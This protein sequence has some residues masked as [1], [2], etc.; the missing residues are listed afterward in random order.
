MADAIQNDAAARGFR[1]RPRG[2]TTADGSSYTNSTTET[3]LDSFT[4]AANTIKHVGDELVLEGSINITSGNS[5]DTLAAKL[6]LGSLTLST[7]GAADVA[8]SGD[9]MHWRVVLLFRAVGAS[10]KAVV[11]H[12]SFNYA[13]GALAATSTQ[14]ELSIDTTASQVAAIRG[15]W[16]NASASNACKSQAMTWAVD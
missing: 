3:T 15:T 9:V 14:G 2:Y 1:K 7:G 13:G 5:T 12:A 10:G 6:K 4:L 16:S 11:K 8:N